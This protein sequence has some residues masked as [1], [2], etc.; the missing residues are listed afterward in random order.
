MAYLSRYDVERLIRDNAPSK[1]RIDEEAT[2][3]LRELLESH[4]SE[5]VQKAIMVALTTN[6]RRRR[7]VKKVKLT[8]TDIEIAASS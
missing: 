6:E 7:A 4:A 2:E 1:I 3:I 5:I 8:K